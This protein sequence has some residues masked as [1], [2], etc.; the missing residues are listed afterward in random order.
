MLLRELFA[1]LRGEDDAPQGKA[2][3]GPDERAQVNVLI[4]NALAIWH[5]SQ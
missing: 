3:Q 1:L 5:Y 2:T 4:C